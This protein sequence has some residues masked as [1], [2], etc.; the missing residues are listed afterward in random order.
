VIDAADSG[1]QFKDAWHGM[2]R[3]SSDVLHSGRHCP[4]R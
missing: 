2:Y 3:V 4:F 1:E